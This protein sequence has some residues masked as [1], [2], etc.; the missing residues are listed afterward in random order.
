MPITV[1]TAIAGII[2]GAI[3][4]RTGRYLEL[5]YAGAAI[6]TLGNGLYIL[7][8]PSSSLTEIICIQIVAGV[9][10]AP[11]FQAP[12]IAIQASVSQDDTA[13]ATSTYSFLRNIATSLSVIL[14]GVLFQNSMD[15]RVPSLAGPPINLPSNITMALTGGNAAANVFLANSIQYPIQKLAIREAYAWSMRNIWIMYTSVSAL[16]L[17]CSV[18]IKRHHLRKDHVETKT[19][20]KKQEAVS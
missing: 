11:L 16:A 15:I 3:I 12:L 1:A 18:F 8:S 19:G 17:V 10:V 4:H 2:V 7:L 9:G 6:M 14:G 5:I 13:T 20:L